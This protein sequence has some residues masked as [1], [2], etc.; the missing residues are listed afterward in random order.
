MCCF[1]TSVLHSFF[2][3]IICT[4][5]WCQSTIILCNSQS[6]FFRLFQ[7]AYFPTTYSTN[8]RRQI[9]INKKTTHKQ[10]HTH[11]RRNSLFRIAKCIEIYDTWNNKSLFFQLFLAKRQ[12][13]SISR[14]THFFSSP[15]I[16]ESHF[17]TFFSR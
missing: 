5:L 4:F 15:Q 2:G 13:N 17:N 6:I 7:N 14:S 11:T 9:E 16:N 10:T 12:F 1:F 8:E 3:P